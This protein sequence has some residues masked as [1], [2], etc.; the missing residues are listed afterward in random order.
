MRSIG[1]AG[2]VFEGRQSN[3]PRRRVIGHRQRISDG[4]REGGGLFV[5]AETIQRSD[6][7]PVRGAGVM[8]AEESFA[9]GRM[10]LSRFDPLVVVMV[11]S[12][13]FLHAVVSRSPGT[14]ASQA[15]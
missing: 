11:A 2:E 9:L 5:E 8:A 6:A 10:R 4:R 15:D 13:G 7:G 3:E 1:L 14:I 12:P